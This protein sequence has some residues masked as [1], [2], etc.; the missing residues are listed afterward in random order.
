MFKISGSKRSAIEPQWFKRQR[1][2]LAILSWSVFAW[3]FFLTAPTN[4]NAAN[5]SWS[6][7]T[8]TPQRVKDVVV[9][10]SPK[11][12]R[13]YIIGHNERGDLVDGGKNCQNDICSGIFMYSSDDNFQ[14]P[15]RVASVPNDKVEKVRATFDIDGTLYIVWHERPNDFTGYMI[16]MDQNENFGS[17]Q[18]L[19]SL[20]NGG[21]RQLYHVDI[22]SSLFPGSDKKL[23]IAAQEKVSGGGHLGIGIYESADG[24]NT[25]SYYAPPL[26]GV[27]EESNGATPRIAVG[28]NG[29]VH[30][31]FSRA[32]K[33]M[34][35]ASKV[36]S[37]ANQDGHNAQGWKV[38]TLESYDGSIVYYRSMSAHPNGKI[39]AAWASFTGFSAGA[40][41]LSIWDPNSKTWG[42]SRFNVTGEDNSAY[43]RIY[44]VNVS[45]GAN[46]QVIINYAV[47]IDQPGGQVCGDFFT[48]V[49]RLRHSASDNQGQS[50]NAPVFVNLEEDLCPPKRMDTQFDGKNRFHYAG[51]FNQRVRYLNASGGGTFLVAPAT[52]VK[53]LP[54]V[55][56]D[57]NGEFE[58]EVQCTT[59]CNQ[60][61]PVIYEVYHRNISIG[62]AWQ[63][64]TRTTSNVVT[65]QAGV[66]GNIHQFYS[67]GIV[68]DKTEAAPAGETPDAQTQISNNTGNSTA[69][70]SYFQ[71]TNPTRIFDTRA[72]SNLPGAGQTLKQG[73]TL[74]ATVIGGNSP[75]PPGAVSMIANVT[76][77]E[78]TGPGFLVV[79]PGNKANPNTSSVNWSRADAQIG[80]MVVVPL[81]PDGKVKVSTSASAGANFTIDVLGYTSANTQTPLFYKGLASPVRVY[82]NDTNGLPYLNGPNKEKRDLKI[83]GEFGIPANAKAVFA[84]VTARLTTSG[85]N[86]VVY[87]RGLTTK[88]NTTTVNYQTASTGARTVANF[89]LIQ[90]SQDGWVTMEAEGFGSA[91]IKIDIIGYLDDDR[92]GGVLDVITPQRLYDSRTPDFGGNNAGKLAVSDN[93]TTRTLTEAFSAVESNAI[94]TLVNVTATDITS[95]G[96]VSLYPGGTNFPGTSTVSYS[97][98]RS[99]AAIR[100]VANFSFVGVDAEK[101]INAMAGNSAAPPVNLILDIVGFI[102]PN[103][104]N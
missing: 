3:V 43:G 25:W 99:N 54:A 85:G 72:G 75:I 28:I 104:N 87:P 10:T 24:G 17:V 68:S 11:T 63:K 2:L 40:V 60:G 1:W 58:L 45:S 92:T 79:Y 95:G 48:F 76:V 94:A 39:F 91:G 18:N 77:S 64:L 97:L 102:V 8:S 47:D 49:S 38:F 23:Y 74:E 62:G 86:T 5:L 41:A 19:N 46:E 20:I 80:N 57:A 67:R 4:V 84:N 7:V 82:D 31:G 21:N 55:I 93:Q 13:T 89:T 90:L 103:P 26:Q 73:G 56:D 6:G 65:F 52:N 71:I 34:F 37:K 70:I 78:T 15:R 69:D 83:A 16:K 27:G 33:G 30:V 42:Q 9:R 101:R 35:V 88:P 53:P 50:W 29:E 81:S 96:F 22:Q 44:D 61:V 32:V 98:D 12:G 59:G 66:P 14:N 100:T 36:P 51:E